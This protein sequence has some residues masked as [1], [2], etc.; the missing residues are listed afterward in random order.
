MVTKPF[1]E[2]ING[3]KVY[4]KLQMRLELPKGSYITLSA[5]CDGQP[6][7]QVQKIVGKGYDV[8]PVRFMINRCDKFELKIEG[9]GPAAILGMNRVF[10][11]GSDR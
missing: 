6:W 4:S 5:R 1:Y 10:A 9:K 2:T 8:I 7:E 3:R 11:M